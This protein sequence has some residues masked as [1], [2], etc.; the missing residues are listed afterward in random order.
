MQLKLKKGLKMP[1]LYDCNQ[2]VPFLNMDEV[3][4]GDIVIFNNEGSLVDDK[5]AKNRLQIDII[6]PNKDVRRI[7]VNKTSRLNLLEVYGNN[8]YDWVNKSAVVK[9]EKITIGGGNK[10][11]L[12]LYPI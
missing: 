5:W 10:R 11:A 3:K 8:T 9:K 1:E 6:L 4:D 2:N 12:I 7:T